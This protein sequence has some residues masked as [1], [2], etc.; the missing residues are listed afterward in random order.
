MKDI[1]CQAREF[2]LYLVIN[3]EPVSDFNPGSDTIIPVFSKITS[4]RRAWEGRLE[5][6]KR[7]EPRR[8]VKRPLPAGEGQVRD[9]WGRGSR[10]QAGRSREYFK[11]RP[12]S[13]V[14]L[15]V[16]NSIRGP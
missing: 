11:V 2:A 9:P 4:M 1:V 14:A 3:R 6:G 7:L 13:S 12:A 16:F 5:V 10:A 8:S 15:Q